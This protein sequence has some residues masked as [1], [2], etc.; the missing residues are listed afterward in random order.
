MDGFDFDK[1]PW[2][3]IFLKF[4]FVLKELDKFILGFI[5]NVKFRV[6]AICYSKFK[7]CQKV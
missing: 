2:S 1:S 3:W 7:H 4:S 5:Q 6:V